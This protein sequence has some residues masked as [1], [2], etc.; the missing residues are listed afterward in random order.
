ME[1]RPLTTGEIAK[2]CHVSHR[3]V[4]KWVTSGKLKSFRTPGNHNRVSLKE[5]LDFL[6][7]YNMPIPSKFKDFSGQRK[8]LI[9]DDDKNMANSIKRL[10]VQEN[11][12]I[13]DIAYDGFDAGRK[14]VWM[15]PDLVVLDIRM[16]G[17]DGYEVARRIKE[18][19]GGKDIKIIAISAFF[20]Q[21]G[22]EKIKQIGADYCLDKP[23][24]QQALID[25]IKEL[26]P[27]ET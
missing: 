21:D 13:I 3:A 5:F 12:Y 7:Q 8:V 24:N 14:I 27:A 22:K 23:F 20:D 10:L 1:D 15:R 4:L 25:K 19:E 16:P 11:Q 2:Y 9:V 6:K 17:L 18:S 26:V